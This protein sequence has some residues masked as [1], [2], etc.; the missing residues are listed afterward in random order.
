MARF[1]TACLT[2]VFTAV[3][4]GQNSPQADSRGDTAAAL[5]RKARRAERQGHSSEAML[6]YSQAAAMSPG[7][8]KLAA[9]AKAL[10]KPESPP[11]AV[12]PPPAFDSITAREASLLQQME[13]PVN[14]V[15][16]PGLEDFDLSGTARALFDQV[17]ARFNLKVV[18]DNDFPAAGPA[19]RFRVTRIGFS[20]ALH[21]L[22]SVTG[23]FVT[24]VSTDHF[25]VAQD[26]PA[27]RNE[28]EQTVALT[29]PFPQ[30]TSTQELTEVTQLLR[31]AFNIE[32]VAVD[33][34][35]DTIVIRDRISRAAPAQALLAQMF[36]YRPEVMVDLEFIE[37][38]DN[39]LRN[40]GFNVTNMVQAVP[41][42]TIFNNA[43]TAPSGA[44]NLLTFGAGK[45]LIGLTVAQAQAL[46]NETISSGRTLF[47]SQVRAID[48]Q[49]ATFKVGE[50]YP[51]Q[52][53]GYF[54]GTGTTTGTTYT[55][56]PVVQFQDLGLQLK[57]TPHLHGSGEVSMA[58]DTSYQLLTG[59]L[60]NGVP[61]I[62]RRQVTTE[63]R[64]KAGEWAIV[65]GL[66]SPVDSK[67]VSG[68]A[69]LAQIPL[70]GNLFKQTSIQ[71]SD[72]HILVAIRPN[73]LSL[74]SDQL[75]PAPLRVGTET[76]PFTP[77]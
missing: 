24:P 48:G 15:G 53:N 39:D 52:T 8:R 33:T 73:V 44:T 34:V 61:V 26:T 28:R 7:D 22:E 71:K 41:L 56:A 29:I 75:T 69:G 23:A 77:F 21:D 42:G 14:L 62:G 47:R 32:K 57:F 10:E 54:G 35:D 20:D 18:Y 25:L 19:L 30:S 45:T 68:F 9:R 36:A 1:A 16:R 17:A 3:C 58:I 2:F 49:A 11:A 74:A 5:V 70:L 50:R 27:K 6:Y 64:L 60:V 12:E 76:R 46:F 65:A 38:S 13:K 55:P 51:V 72:S 40:Y 66:M 37:V 67:A 63:V 43:T 31:Q 59:E 4:A